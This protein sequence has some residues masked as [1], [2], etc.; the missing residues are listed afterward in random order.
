[1]ST[2]IYNRQPYHNLVTFVEVCALE[3]LHESMVLNTAV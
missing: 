3:V 2:C 1:M